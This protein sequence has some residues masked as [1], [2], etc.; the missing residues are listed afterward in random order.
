MA[1]T[2]TAGVK[3]G[4]MLKL[5]QDAYAQKGFDGEWKFHHQGGCAAY[6]SREW[7]ANPSVNRV[8]G[9]N[10]AYAWNPSVAGTKSED[11]V[12][13]YANA[14]GE[15]VVEVITSS[16]GWPVIEQTIGDI[17]IARP[18]ILHLPL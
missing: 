9:L 12:L 14:Q 8:M 2:R 3:A 11:T 5:A 15:P 18:T 1:N 6:K 17:T 13:C 4:D 10:Q 16:P 7:V